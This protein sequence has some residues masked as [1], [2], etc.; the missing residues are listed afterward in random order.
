MTKDKLEP[1][2]KPFDVRPVRQVSTLLSD[3]YKFSHRALY[4][5]GTEYVYS[6]ETPRANSYFP[7]NDKMVAFGYEMFVQR[8]LVEHFNENFFN[9]P[10]SDVLADYTYIVENALGSENA[11][12]EHIEALHN[13]GYLPIWVKA[14]P[15][16]IQV[17]MKVPVL[18]IENTNPDFF[19]L[20]NFLETLLLSETFVTSTVASMARELQALCLEF[21]EKTADSNEYVPFQCHDF[22]ERGQHGN[23]ASLLSGLG[24]LTSFAGSDTIQASIM[25][26]NYYGADLESEL[27][28][29]SVVASEH[30]VM[31]SYGT[32]EVNTY[33]TLLRKFTE[34]ILSLVSDT[35]DY[36]GVLTNVLPTLKS[37][38]LARN[39]KTVI[40]PDSGDPATIIA[41]TPVVNF[42]IEVDYDS[43]DDV[44][45]TLLVPNKGVDNSLIVEGKGGL[46][47]VELEDIWGDGTW[48]IGNI[49]PNYEP[50]VEDK[51]TLE[52]LWDTFGGTVNSKGYK[53]L[54]P[55]IGLLY[56]EGITIDRAR[57][58][59]ERMEA[60]GFSAENVVFGVGAFVYSVSV[61]RDSFNIAFKSQLVVIDGEEKQIFKDP[62]TD[63][64]HIKRSLKGKVVV[65]EEDGQLVAHDGYSRTDIVRG[66]LLQ[67][68]FKDGERTRFTPFTVI[69]D[70]IADSI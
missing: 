61:S 70:R 53:V 36:F 65:L 12:T 13:L 45:Y 17:P 32:D 39:G 33:R 46:Y 4:P 22:S 50:T 19:W 56:G 35:Y 57:Q 60:K 27:I 24:H 23:D 62:K 67:T 7:W 58:I 59:F 49:T 9:L 63:V 14:L 42:D 55:H 52:L 68:I 44:L 15:E 11:D 26:H 18:T 38:V 37:D 30:S 64:N 8:W 47:L 20:T 5:E 40:R 1:R 31:Q 43:L 54:D 25:A 16:G 2:Q 3:C 10:L 6:T 34:G 69:K 48:S 66:D 41:G 51:G 28:L 21:A 29:K